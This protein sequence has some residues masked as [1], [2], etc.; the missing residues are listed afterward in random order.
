MTGYR[1]VG[2]PC[3]HATPPSPATAVPNL[4]FVQ[5]LL[6]SL[7]SSGPYTARFMCVSLPPTHTSAETRTPPFPRTPTPPAVTRG[8]PVAAPS[9]RPLAWTIPYWIL[10]YRSCSPGKA[11]M[12][13]PWV[14]R[15]EGGRERSCLFLEISEILPGSELLSY[16]KD[17]TA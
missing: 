8:S 11:M 15:G 9:A 16:I 5:L 6:V 17:E 10:S 2:A 12:T 7:Y 1:V 13:C 14:S 4:Y 3:L